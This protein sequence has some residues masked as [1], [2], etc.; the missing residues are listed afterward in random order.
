MMDG[1]PE[2]RDIKQDYQPHWKI[3]QELSIISQLSRMSWKAET[4]I[5]YWAQKFNELFFRSFSVIGWRLVKAMKY[6]QSL[7]FKEVSC[8]S[9]ISIHPQPVGERQSCG[10]KFIDIEPFT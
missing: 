1:Q 6:Q 8:M 4:K 10:Y 5:L 9:G 3:N 2:K 7:A